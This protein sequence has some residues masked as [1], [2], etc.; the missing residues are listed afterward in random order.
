MYILLRLCNCCIII[1][2]FFITG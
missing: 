1:I 2:T